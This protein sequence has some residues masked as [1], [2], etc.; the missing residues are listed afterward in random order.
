MKKQYGEYVIEALDHNN[1]IVFV[2]TAPEDMNDGTHF[3]SFADA[4][5]ACDKDVASKNRVKSEKP[6]RTDRPLLMANGDEI[7]FRGIDRRSKAWIYTDST[8]CQMKIERFDSGSFYGSAPG[9][10][11]LLDR[12]NA[13]AAQIKAINRALSKA[14]VSFPYLGYKTPRDY[15]EAMNLTKRAIEE[16][17]RAEAAASKVVP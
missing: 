14:Q 5:A 6:I 1:K 11:A 2:V 15:A 7:T 3:N 17:D 12:K 8:G 10:K 9:V 16:I 13:L 4:A